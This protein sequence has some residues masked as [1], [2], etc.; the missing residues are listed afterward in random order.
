MVSDVLKTQVAEVADAGTETNRP[1]VP[2]NE[3]LSAETQSQPLIFGGEWRLALDATEACQNPQPAAPV[4]KFVFGEHSK[5]EDGVTGSSSRS[6]SAGPVDIMSS[7]KTAGNNSSN[8]TFKFRH[9][10]TSSIAPPSFTFNVD[11]PI[12]REQ[13]GRANPS[14]VADTSSSSLQTAYQFGSFR[15]LHNVTPV[16]SPKAEPFRVPDDHIFDFSLPSPKSLSPRAASNLR[17][18]GGSRS[19]SV[20]DVLGHSLGNLAGRPSAELGQS[21]TSE[22]TLPL[23]NR[24]HSDLNTSGAGSEEPV[25]AYNVLN[26][27][28]PHH[29]FFSNAFQAT[30]QRGVNIAKAAADVLKSVQS[31]QGSSLDGLLKEAEDLCLFHGTSTR[32]IGILGDSGQGMHNVQLTICVLLPLTPRR[33]EQSYKLFTA[34][35]QAR[36]NCQ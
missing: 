34:F 7:T 9:S 25:V 28:T 13:A 1:V 20:S 16:P 12:S 35:P 18:R 2:Q 32:T 31:V 8:E 5:A 17:S 10:T 26:E 27:E 21:S 33:Q 4:P 22:P 29:P 14:N 6:K 23:R 36:K 11:L 24:S 3:A 15:G 19:S 30:L